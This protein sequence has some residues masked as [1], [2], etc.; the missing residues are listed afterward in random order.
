MMRRRW[1]K[2]RAVRDSAASKMSATWMD[3]FSAKG[4]T[5]KKLEKKR[6]DKKDERYNTFSKYKGRDKV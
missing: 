5:L 3:I 4:E 2:D 1:E 6:D